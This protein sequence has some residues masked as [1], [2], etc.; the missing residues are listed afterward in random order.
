MKPG[1]GQRHWNRDQFERL[2][3]GKWRTKRG[4]FSFSF[5]EAELV[6]NGDWAFEWG[7]YSVTVQEETVETGKNLWIYKWEADGL[8]R[9][10]RTIYNSGS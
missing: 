10:G 5:D 4:A 1:V 2:A 6:V 8:W 7:T 9:F 3:W